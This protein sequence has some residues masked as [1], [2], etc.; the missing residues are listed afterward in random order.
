MDTIE[1][2]ITPTSH[3]MDSERQHILVV[4]DTQEI[5][6]LFREILEEE[7][8]RVSLY[9]STFNDVSRSRCSRTRRF[10]LSMSPAATRPIE[11]MM[12]V[13]IVAET[14]TQPRSSATRCRSADRVIGPSR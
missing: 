2:A 10:V 6:E 9:S 5:L 11:S 1:E 12:S 14:R 3:A 13:R 4:N 8:Y 7:G